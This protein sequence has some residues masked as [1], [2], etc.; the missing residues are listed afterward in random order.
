MCLIKSML[1]EKVWNK[2]EDYCST[3]GTFLSDVLYNENNWNSFE[4]WASQN[5]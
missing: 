3:K 2:L 1:G 4:K 5:N